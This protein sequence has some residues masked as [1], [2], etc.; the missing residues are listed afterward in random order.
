MEQNDKDKDEDYMSTN[1]CSS[2]EG[3]FSSCSSD[4]SKEADKGKSKPTIR[5]KGKHDKINKKKQKDVE[6]DKIIKRIEDE[7]I[8]MLQT[9]PK[10]RKN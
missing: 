3:Y 5:I 7:H 6:M 8:T 4:S 9:S 2:Y 1:S 10:E